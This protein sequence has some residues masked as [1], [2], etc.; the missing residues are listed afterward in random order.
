MT[1]LRFNSYG[2]LGSFVS[3]K[4]EFTSRLIEKGY[5]EEYTPE[6]V[7]ITQAG[8]GILRKFEEE[9]S[10]RNGGLPRSLGPASTG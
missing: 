3:K 1:L 2:M 6:R 8:R 9:L 4:D 7:R 5:M 10:D